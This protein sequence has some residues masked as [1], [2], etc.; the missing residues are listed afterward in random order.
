MNAQVRFEQ[1]SLN[2]VS[3]LCM[4]VIRPPMKEQLEEQ[5]AQSFAY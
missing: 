3:Y 2:T 1:P 4:L 5:E